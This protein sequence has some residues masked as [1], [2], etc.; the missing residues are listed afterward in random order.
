MT[1][2]AKGPTVAGVALLGVDWSPSPQCKPDRPT[3]TNRHPTPQT[4]TKSTARSTCRYKLLLGGKL[5]RTSGPTDWGTN[6]RPS[7]HPAGIVI[8]HNAVLTLDSTPQVTAATT[9]SEGRMGTGKV[10]IASVLKICD[11]ASGLPYLD[12]GR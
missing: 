11:N 10:G 9:H 12:P 2:A 8:P 4:A 3:R 1:R 7:G 6:N 5:V